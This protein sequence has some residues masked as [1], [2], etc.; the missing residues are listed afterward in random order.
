MLT[1]I[2]KKIIKDYEE[3]KKQNFQENIQYS[4]SEKFHDLG[5]LAKKTQEKQSSNYKFLKNKY[6]YKDMRSKQLGSFKGGTLTLSKNE[7]SKISA[8]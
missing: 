3:K 8:S 4:S 6:K 2:R 1:G 5:F 7:I